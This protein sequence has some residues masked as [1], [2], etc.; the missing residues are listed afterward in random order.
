MNSSPSSECAPRGPGNIPGAAVCRDLGNSGNKMSLGQIPCRGIHVL[1]GISLGISAGRGAVSMDCLFQ[2]LVGEKREFHGILRNSQPGPAREGPT[3]PTPSLFHLSLWDEPEG[4]FL[5]FELASNPF[6]AVKNLG[7]TL[8]F[9]KRLSS[10]IPSI[11]APPARDVADP[12]GSS[13]LC[14]TGRIPRPRRDN[15]GLCSPSTHLHAQE[16]FPWI[17]PRDC[18]LCPHLLRTK[19]P[20]RSLEEPG[21]AWHF[22]GDEFP[23]W[24]SSL[25]RAIL[26][27]VLDQPAG[28]EF[29]QDCRILPLGSHFC[30]SGIVWSF[31]F[32]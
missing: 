9:G 1:V 8:I 3:P 28:V 14:A 22:P 21:G 18:S 17:V 29:L 24:F 4:F 15:A 30:S 16:L 20:W 2:I 31:V 19:E 27:I 13:S 32:S 12:C 11:P 5:L 26:W 10:A 6:S 7:K 25:L 23:L